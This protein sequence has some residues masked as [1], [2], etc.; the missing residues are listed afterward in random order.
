VLG[1]PGTVATATLLKTGRFKPLLQVLGVHENTIEVVPPPAA[2]TNPALLTAATVGWLEVQVPV[3][4][5]TVLPLES[6]TDELIACVL[7][8]PVSDVMGDGV[9]AIEAT[10]HSKNVKGM[11]FTCCT[12]PSLAKICVVPGSFAVTVFEP[13]V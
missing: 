8:P 6:T 1:V 5:L 7:P 3:I 13:F 9:I 10:G 2:V 12:L 4:P 11:L